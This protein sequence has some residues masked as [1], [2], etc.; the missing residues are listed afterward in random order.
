MKNTIISGIALAFLFSLSFSNDVSA[1]SAMDK[2]TELKTFHS[3]M[4]QT[5]HPM[6]EGNFDPIRK[7]SGEMAQ[8]AA[9]L[10]KS[11][12]PAEFNK[13]EMITAMK[14][15]KG[16]SKKLDKIIKKGAA[17][18][19]VGKQLVALHDTFH[20]IVGICRGEDH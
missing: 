7:R 5:F 9:A 20:T 3:V 16:D 12:I 17:D 11:A 15:L 13:P 8:K 6:E 1:Q 10:A 19:V 14:A 2:W 4:S 18:D